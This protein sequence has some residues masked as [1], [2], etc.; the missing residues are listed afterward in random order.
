MKGGAEPSQNLSKSQYQPAL[1]TWRKHSIGS[2]QRKLNPDV[3]D[4]A[5]F[6]LL[7]T[8]RIPS[9]GSV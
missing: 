6:S 9:V 8:C 1:S 2:T 4:V 5:L 7:A 3:K